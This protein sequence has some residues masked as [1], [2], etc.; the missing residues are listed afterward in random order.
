VKKISG[1]TSGATTDLDIITFKYIYYAVITVMID[2]D[3]KNNSR[4]NNLLG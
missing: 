3:S 4:P 1:A 2:E